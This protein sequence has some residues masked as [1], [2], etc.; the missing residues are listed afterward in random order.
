[1]YSTT[2]T[3]ANQHRLVS[4]MPMLRVHD[5]VAICGAIKLCANTTVI[6]LAPKLKRVSSF[7]YEVIYTC[8]E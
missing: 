4:A 3:Y 7:T 2:L 6:Y 8:L 1:V 5:D